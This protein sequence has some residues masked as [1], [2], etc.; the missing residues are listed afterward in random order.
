MAEAEIYSVI[1]GPILGELGPETRM[2]EHEQCPSCSRRLPAEVEFLHYAFDFWEGQPLACVAECFAVVPE[3]RLA[4]EQAG[5]KGLIF[6]EMKASFSDYY[7]PEE[8]DQPLP[9]FVE[10]RPKNVLT[11]GPGWWLPAG[12][13]SQCGRREWDSTIYTINAIVS[14]H[15]NPKLPR[16]SVVRSAYDGEDFFRIDD[17]GPSLMSGRMLALLRSNGVEGLEV[18]P[19]NFVDRSD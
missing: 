5:M 10:M 8:G 3:L 7:E 1:R 17:P 12:K 2:I 16:R 13:C 15:E 19:A 11:A 14:A 9:A 4:I 18:Q 6:R